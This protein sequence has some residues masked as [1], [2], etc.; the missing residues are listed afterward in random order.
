M[1]RSGP[2]G[3]CGA[4]GASKGSK[5]KGDGTGNGSKGGSKGK[6]KGKKGDRLVL[7][8][9]PHLTDVLELLT[10][11]LHRAESMRDDIDE[12]IRQAIA[13]EVGIS[14]PLWGDDSEV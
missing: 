2:Y 8:P 7:V 13:A 11:V 14:R 3:D 10:D 4:G 1:P 6:G 9:A 12:L 5:G